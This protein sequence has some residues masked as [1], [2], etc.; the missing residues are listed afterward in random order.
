MPIRDSM[1]GANLFC[2]NVVCIRKTGRENAVVAI[3]T[4]RNA[5]QFLAVGL[6]G[7]RVCGFR[8]A[9]PM[10]STNEAELTGFWCI[11]AF[12]P[13]MHIVDHYRVAIDDTGRACNHRSGLMFGGWLQAKSSQC[14][15]DGNGGQT[16]R[17]IG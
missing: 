2:I 5:A 1:T 16:C 13:D 4:G 15:P 3:Q 7:K 11:D 17:F 12:Q 10:L 14:N 8:S 9:A 6:L